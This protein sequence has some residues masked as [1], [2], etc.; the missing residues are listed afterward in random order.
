MTPQYRVIEEVGPDHDKIFTLGVYVGDKLMGKGT[1]PSKQVA[2]Q[3]AA[4][5]ALEEY[6]RRS[7]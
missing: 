2:Q 5:A 6:A 3:Q 7:N 1:G 4:Q